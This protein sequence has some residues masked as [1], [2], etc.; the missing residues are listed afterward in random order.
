MKKLKPNK[1][2]GVDGLNSSFILEIAEAIAKPQRIIFTKTLTS[3]VIPG[4]WKCAN[5][6][7]IF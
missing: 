1:T 6:T 4:D 5:V 3:G 2:G 7:A